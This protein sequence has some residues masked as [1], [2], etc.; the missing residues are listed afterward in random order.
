[1]LSQPRKTRRLLTRARSG[2]SGTPIFFFRNHQSNKTFLNAK[3]RSPEPNVLSK[4]TL[5]S[6]N[7]VVQ[8]HAM[9]RIVIILLQPGFSALNDLCRSIRRFRAHSFSYSISRRSSRAKLFPS[10][11]RASEKGVMIKLP[12]FR[13]KPSRAGEAE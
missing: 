3:A 5:Y 10:S 2:A 7:S 8:L 12:V 13:N 4:T 11:I 1:M 6:S 9:R